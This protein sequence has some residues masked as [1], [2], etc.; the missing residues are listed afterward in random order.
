MTKFRPCIDLHQGKV[1]QIVGGTLTKDHSELKVNFTSK[2]SAEEFAKLYA[3]DELF[4]GHVIML[5]PE[6]ESAGWAPMQQAIRRRQPPC[7]R[8]ADDGS[9][10]RT[11]A[12]QWRRQGCPQAP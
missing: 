8:H 5:G 7:C 6:N 2:T 11:E 12:C 3:K 9:G 1:R 4:G 10:N